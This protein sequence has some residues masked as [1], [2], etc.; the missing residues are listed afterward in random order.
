MKQ[1]LSELYFKEEINPN[2]KVL[3]RLIK[4]LEINIINDKKFDLV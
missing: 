1:L 3:K 2:N 4:R